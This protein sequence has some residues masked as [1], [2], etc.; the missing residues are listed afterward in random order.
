MPTTHKFKNLDR[1]TLGLLLSVYTWD[2]YRV[3]I[4]DYAPED[5][6]TPLHLLEDLIP[7][8]LK[9]DEP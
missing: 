1:S 2:L 3:D 8:V 7:E 4:K 5:I 6:K 9:Y